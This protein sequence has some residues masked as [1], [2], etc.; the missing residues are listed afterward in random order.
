MLPMLYMYLLVMSIEYSR[1]KYVEY[2]TI[3]LVLNF[4]QL[5]ISSLAGEKIK[6]N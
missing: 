1:K 4:L 5:Y 6:L 2:P 3:L